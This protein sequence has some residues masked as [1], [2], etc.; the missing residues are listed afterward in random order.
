MDNS[1]LRT[2]KPETAVWRAGD[3]SPLVAI[4]GENPDRKMHRGEHEVHRGKRE[5]SMSDGLMPFFSIS[6]SFGNMG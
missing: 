2:P 4:C 6:F 3:V 5:R 1:R